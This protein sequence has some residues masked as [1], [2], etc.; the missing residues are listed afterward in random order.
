[1]TDARHLPLRLT[2]QGRAPP[3][4]RLRR[5]RPPMTAPS[6]VHMRQ[7]RSIMIPIS[8]VGV[9][10]TDALMNDLARHVASGG[11]LPPLALPQG[12]G[13][14]WLAARHIFDEFYSRD[15]Y[16]HEDKFVKLAKQASANGSAI[17]AHRFRA[18]FESMY[19]PRIRFVDVGSVLLDLN[20]PRSVTHDKDV[21]TAQL[22]ALVSLAGC[23]VYS[24]DKHLRR[25][26]IAPNDLAPVVA[27]SHLA[28]LGD[29]ATAGTSA[30]GL[31]SA[32]LLNE[33]VAFAAR[34]LRV[35]KLVAWSALAVLIAWTMSDEQR[36]QDASRVLIPSGR[37]IAAS[38]IA[39]EEGRRAL[40]AVA[41]SLTDEVPIECRV[42]KILVQSASPVLVREVRRELQLREEVWPVP[43]DQRLRALPRSLPCFVEVERHRWQLGEVLASPSLHRV[44][45]FRSV[46]VLPQDAR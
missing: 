19:L 31:A 36:R 29:A 37:A 42:A 10:D 44:P 30:L 18:A 39:G 4:R 21:P 28:S 40:D 14:A 24:H 16:G 33:G 34:T 9:L 8:R 35:P 38:W 25:P 45:N 22:A 2:E 23:V 6:K 11:R 43:T 46:A 27:A 41:V 1:M 7:T 15:D 17:E 20:L 32:F 26:G 12:L 5:V 3:W 13:T